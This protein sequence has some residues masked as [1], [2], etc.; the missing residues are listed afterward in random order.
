MNITHDAMFGLA[1][2]KKHHRPQE[3]LTPPEVLTFVRAL[4]QDTVALDPCAGTSN[5]EHVD[6]DEHYTEDQDGLVRSWTDRTYVNPPYKFL[7]QW[8]SKA[9]LEAEHGHRIV[10]LCPVR[11]HRDWWHKYR[12]TASVEVQLKP[13]KFVG[14]D[15]AFSAPLCLL[16]WNGLSSVENGYVDVEARLRA[17]ELRY[18]KVTYL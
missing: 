18:T 10:M 15:G 6:A 11:G 13:L 3:I 1:T 4:W 7:K 2:G 5:P 17:A 9:S 12:D 8:M 16:I 14:Y